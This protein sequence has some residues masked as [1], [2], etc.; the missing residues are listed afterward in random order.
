LGNRQWQTLRKGLQT[1]AQKRPSDVQ[2]W[3][4]GMQLGAAVKQLPPA[5]ELIDTAARTPRPRRWAIAALIAAVLI[6]GGYWLSNQYRFGP[7]PTTAAADGDA[8]SPDADTPGAAAA[9]AV[10]PGASVPGAAGMRAA[11]SPGAASLP[12]AQPPNAGAPGSAAPP[13]A[14]APRPSTKVSATPPPPPAAVVARATPPAATAAPV[15]AHPGPQAPGASKVEMAV[16]TMDASLNDSVVHVTVRRKGNLHGQTSFTWWTESGTAKPGV[17]FVAVLPHVQQMQ[18]GEA[19]I[20]LSVP[21][22]STVRSQEKGFYVGIEEAD[23][24]AQIG[25]RSLTQITLPPTN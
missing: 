1:D 5:N 10:A 14:A 18:D 9:G 25:A 2:S 15:V 12:A 13:M 7:Q 19:S 4:H 6:G 20:V 22:L 11:G 21:V 17:D 23:G 24:G 16:D 8:V 3:L